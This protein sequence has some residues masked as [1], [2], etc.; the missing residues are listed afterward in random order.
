VGQRG[1]K[2]AVDPSRPYSFLVEPERNADGSIAQVATIFL[3]NR[4]CP[5][6]C[7]MCDLWRNTSDQTV[8]G[9]AIPA[10][11]DFAL[12]RLEPASEIKLYNSGSF[13]DPAAIP[14]EDWPAIADRLR[15]FTR[16]IVECHPA[17]VNERLLRFRDLLSGKLE[18]AMGLETANPEVLPQLNKRMS[19]DDFAS[20]ATFLHSHDIALRAFVLVFPPF[21][22]QETRF[23]WSRRSVE[24]AFDCHATAVSLI[25]TRV[26]NG[27]LDQLQAHGFFTSPSLHDLEQAFQEALSLRRRRVFADVWDLQQFSRCSHC[28]AARTQRLREMNMTQIFTPPI[29]CSHC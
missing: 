14:V 7:V 11:I 12:S 13:F 23:E 2:N 17:L 1:P 21:Q 8:P 28:L 25:P 29:Q 19:L 3:T 4:E 5:W 9:G 16:V 24:F 20:A 6:R 15:S 10:Q 22:P 27:A 26:G 18:I